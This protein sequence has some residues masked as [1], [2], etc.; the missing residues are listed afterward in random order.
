MEK[1]FFH[2]ECL[3]SVCPLH[4]LFIRSEFNT[5]YMIYFSI[6]VAFSASAELKFIRLCIMGSDALVSNQ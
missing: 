4:V 6:F 3:L 1:H 5:N 2:F